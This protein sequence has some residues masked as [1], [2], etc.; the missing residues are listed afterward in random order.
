MTGFLWYDFA[1]QK[2]AEFGQLS[3]N[4]ERFAANS[5][6]LT[7]YAA[8]QAALTNGDCDTANNYVNLIYS[9]LRAVLVQ[10]FISAVYRAALTAPGPSS[11]MVEA[12]VMAIQLLPFV[13][14]CSASAATTIRQSLDLANS[15][16]SINAPALIIALQGTYACLSVKCSDVGSTSANEGCVDATTTS[17]STNA[18]SQAAIAGIVVLC[19]LVYMC[20][21]GGCFTYG[22]AVGYRRAQVDQHMDGIAGISADTMHN[23]SSS[24]KWTERRSND[25]MR[26]GEPNDMQEVE[27]V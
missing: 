1:K 2:A 7:L 17:Y 3:A 22:K 26:G 18:L 24:T 10:G 25:G 23:P 20:S 8:G 6:L 21:M 5:V 4:K 27:V 19:I 15:V 13:S 12:W 9:Q 14:Q 16:S 11:A